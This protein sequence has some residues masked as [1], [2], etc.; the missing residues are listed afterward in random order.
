MVLT[1]HQLCR[2]SLPVPGTPLSHGGPRRLAPGAGMDL[3]SVFG[4][5]LLPGCRK[6]E[7]SPDKRRS[8][9]HGVHRERPSLEMRALRDP[10]TG[11]APLTADARHVPL[12]PRS[13]RGFPGIAQPPFSV[14]LTVSRGKSQCISSPYLTPYAPSMAPRAISLPRRVIRAS[15]LRAKHGSGRRSA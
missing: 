5:E 7:T 2:E 15:L 14:R 10:R 13:F 11:F 8:E 12:G 4:L 9:E 3:N 6:G 1:G